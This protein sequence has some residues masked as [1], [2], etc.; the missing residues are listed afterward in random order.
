MLDCIKKN[1]QVLDY[2]LPLLAS[3]KNAAIELS[4]QNLITSNYQELALT[5]NEDYVFVL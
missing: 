1:R 5:K 2:L 3:E 4:I